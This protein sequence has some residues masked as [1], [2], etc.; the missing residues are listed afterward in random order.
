MMK[1]RRYLVFIIVFV[2]GYFLF[3]DV[4]RNNASS[5]HPAQQLWK[6]T[7]PFDIEPYEYAAH[8]EST[9][10]VHLGPVRWEDLPKLTQQEM[11]MH[12]EVLLTLEWF[13]DSVSQLRTWDRSEMDMYLDKLKEGKCKGSYMESCDMFEN[14]FKKFPVK[15]KDVL[16]VGSQSP[17][18]EAIALHYGASSVSTVDF[19]KPGD[20]IHYERFKILSFHE[21]NSTYDM[22][23]SYSSLEH[24][25]LGRYGDPIHP[26]GDLLRMKAL[27]NLLKPQGILF[28][29]VPVGTDA[30][31][32]NGHRIYGKVRL[33]KM[34]E[35]FKKVG[36]F[37]ASKFPMSLE[38]YL[39]KPIEP[40]FSWGNQPLIVLQK[41]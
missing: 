14:A 36:Y 35:G 12:C 30:L 21:V 15:D 18:V 1:F 10:R 13:N 25:G 6:P 40:L 27:A 41:N 19:Q 20:G 2:A 3:S 5:T 28:L 17:W 33:T 32:F 24:D 16:V 4:I 7:S 23:A 37:P 38:E 8:G 9:P 26:N 31:C 11:L 22:I 29:G 39:E 34:F